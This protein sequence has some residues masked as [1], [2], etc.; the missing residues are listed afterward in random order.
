M[1][2]KKAFRAKN[3][4]T[5]T[6][7][8]MTVIYTYS[9]PSSFQLSKTKV[10]NIKTIKIIKYNHFLLCRY[11]KHPH[12]VRIPAVLTLFTLF[13]VLYI[14]MQFACNILNFSDAR[15]ASG[16]SHGLQP[17]TGTHTRLN[18]HTHTY[19]Q[20]HA[21]TLT[22]NPL[23]HHHSG[24]QVGLSATFSPVCIFLYVIIGSCTIKQTRFH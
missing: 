8:T 5:S 14:Q 13:T 23:M 4:F 10:K 16:F 18:T 7:C 22:E 15:C 17:W 2:K 12:V 21:H 1:T 24:T 11:S 9:S 3:T 6:K 20:T 19:G